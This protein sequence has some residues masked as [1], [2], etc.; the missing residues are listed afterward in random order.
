MSDKATAP[1]GGGFFIPDRVVLWFGA[2]RHQGCCC[3]SLQGMGAVPS[4]EE[5]FTCYSLFSAASYQGKAM[6]GT[7]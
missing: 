6:A 7:A 3:L 5:W 4:R 1:K 2:P